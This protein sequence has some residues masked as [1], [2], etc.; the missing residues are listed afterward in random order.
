MLLYRNWG[1]L[2]VLKKGHVASPR[3]EDS[4]REG[5]GGGVY[6]S[7]GGKKGRLLTPRVG[8]RKKRTKGRVSKRPRKKPIFSERGKKRVGV[9]EARGEKGSINKW[10]KK[11]GDEG[12]ILHHEERKTHTKTRGGSG[13][14]KRRGIRKRKKKNHSGLTLRR[15]EQAVWRKTQGSEI[16]CA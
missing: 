9:G 4:G 2:T 6:N 7:K 3:R 8:L 5:G 14:K 16:A 11:R 1:D 13:Q 12:E 10:I 15:R